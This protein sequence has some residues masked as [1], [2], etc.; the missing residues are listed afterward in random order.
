[1]RILKMSNREKGRRP[2]RKKIRKCKVW[3]Y[4]YWQLQATFTVL[5][6]VIRWLWGQNQ[7]WKNTTLGMYINRIPHWIRWSPHTMRWGINLTHTFFN[8]FWGSYRGKNFAIFILILFK[9]TFQKKNQPY[10]LRI[11]RIINIG[12]SNFFKMLKKILCIQNDHSSVN[13]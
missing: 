4:C 7:S 2:A 9:G 3:A 1:M 12:L 10:I 5:E 13:S 11:G 6:K 8:N